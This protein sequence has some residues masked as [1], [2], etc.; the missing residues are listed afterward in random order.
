MGSNPT[1]SAR[2]NTRI[3]LYAGVIIS[4]SMAREVF[5]E[6]QAEGYLFEEKSSDWY[7]ALGIIAVAGAIASV[8]FG[9]IIL[10]LLVLVAA[11]TLALSTLKQPRMHTFSI[12]EEGVMIDDTLYDYDSIISFSVLEYID[13]KLPPALSLRTHKLLAPHLIIPIV[14]PDPLEIYEFFVEHIEEG[15][16]DESIVDRVIDLLR[17]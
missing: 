6:W 3:L 12:T 2:D 16:H 5:Y 1:S 9:N 14:G 10:A 8:L 7:W 15:K 11:G 4:L 17:L 13:P